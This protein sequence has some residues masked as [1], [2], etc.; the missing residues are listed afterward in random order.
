MKLTKPE[1]AIT[2][3]CLLVIGLIIAGLIYIRVSAKNDSNRQQVS[4]AQP[5][6]NIEVTKPE[7]NKLIETNTV[8]EQI[9]QSEPTVKQEQKEEIVRLTFIA[10]HLSLILYILNM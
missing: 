10:V 7:E 5:K 9:A 1:K 2:I 3:L 8:Q 6:L 4:T